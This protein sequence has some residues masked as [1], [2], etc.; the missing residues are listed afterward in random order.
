MALIYSYT[1][2]AH[3]GLQTHT[4]PYGHMILV[5]DQTFFIRF[6]GHAHTLTPNLIGFVPPGVLHDFGCT[7][8]ELT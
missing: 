5:L 8:R 6:A 7:D 4:H 1:F 3:E 2:Y